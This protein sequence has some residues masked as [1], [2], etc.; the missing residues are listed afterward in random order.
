MGR[1]HPIDDR[2]TQCDADVLLAI[3]DTLRSAYE[4]VLKQPMPNNMRAL[5][6]RLEH[7]TDSGDASPD[8]DPFCRVPGQRPL[9]HRA[10][11]DESDLSAL[12]LFATTVHQ[13]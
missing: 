4:D 1:S 11:Q 6:A 2:P 13:G 9:H 10:G 5:L 7:Q 8:A 12:G 3:R